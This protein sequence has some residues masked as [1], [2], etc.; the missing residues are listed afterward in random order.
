MPILASDFTTLK[1][2]YIQWKMLSPPNGNRTQAWHN[3]WSQ[4]QHHPFWPK[5]TF[6]CKTETS[7]SLHSH[8]LLVIVK[9]SQF[10]KVQKS[11][12]AWAEVKDLLSS[13]WQVNVE[14]K[15]LDLESGVMTG[16]GSIPTRGN[17]FSLDFFCFHVVKP[18]LP[19]LALLPFLCILK[20]TLL[21][22]IA[23]SDVKPSTRTQPCYFV[24]RWKPPLASLGL[25]FPSTKILCDHTKECFVQQTSFS[26][27]NTI[28]GNNC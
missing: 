1:Q 15:V 2:K 9:S 17:I 23:H 5:L 22:M 3:L 25:G 4:V 26:N 12:G 14:R 7:G 6:A 10:L 20:K 11:T 16:L 27:W 8:A 28:F 21:S 18:L 13:T 24:H 19:I